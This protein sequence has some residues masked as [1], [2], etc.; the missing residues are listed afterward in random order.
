MT[1]PADYDGA[2]FFFQSGAEESAFVP[3][4]GGFLCSYDPGAGDVLFFR[5]E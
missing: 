3:V 2:A 4:S 1:C 5:G